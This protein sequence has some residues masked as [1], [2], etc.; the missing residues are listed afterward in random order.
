LSATEL[1]SKIVDVVI[2]TDAF[3]FDFDFDFAEG[4]TM[5]RASGGLAN[6]FEAMCC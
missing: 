2:G 3:A 1:D 6:I 5:G 4:R